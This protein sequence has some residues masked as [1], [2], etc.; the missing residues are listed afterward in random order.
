VIYAFGNF[1]MKTRLTVLAYLIS[2]SNCIAQFP[3]PGNC[4]D[5][6]GTANNYVDIADVLVDGLSVITVEA[7]IYP[8]SLPNKNNP[9]GHNN[10]EGAI[11]HKSG[12]SDDNL[13]LTV[14]TGGL[15][16]YIDNGSNNTL[17]GNAPATNT[18]THVAASYDGTTLRIYQNGILDVSQ[19]STGSNSLVNNTNNLRIGG[20]HISGGSPHEFTGR[21]DE[22]RVWSDLRTQAEIR[23]NMCQKL[24][25]TEGNLELYYRMDQTSATSV[26]DNSVNTNNGSLGPG[27][28]SSTDWVTSGAILGDKSTYS[29][30]VTTSTSLNI[31]SADGDDLTANVTA[32]IVEPE[33][34]HIYRVDE[35]PN[36]T[37]PP[38]TQVQLSQVGYFGA[39]VF[40]GTVVTY[41]VVYDYDG[42]AG[43]ADENDLELAK[44][45]DNADVDWSQETAILNTTANT[46][47]LVGETGAEYILATDNADNILPIVLLSFS[48]IQ[49]N[50]GYVELIWKTAFEINND[51]FSIERSRNG[52][53]WEILKTIDGSG[54]SNTLLSYESTDQNPYTGISY[55]R[56]KQTDFDGQFTHS[57]VSIVNIYNS[58]T[59]IQ[60]FPNPSK[61]LITIDG[62][63][64]VLDQMKIYNLHGQDVTSQTRQIHKNESTMVIDLSNLNKGLY[65]LKTK[66]TSNKVYKQ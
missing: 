48:A 7:W 15:A 16:F 62:N 40:G 34:M 47:T 30:S 37:T 22:V 3:G 60:I 38:G 56:L 18:W 8:T 11:I 25:G 41:T 12:A 13:G 55:Y 4:L 31:A 51:Y 45:D 65:Y 1:E 49:T 53:D 50:R 57:Q 32:L 5:F 26:S 59:E 28:D 14:A 27:M 46:L 61:K 66:T 44:R 58:G 20:G 36:V 43:I 52:S 39:K 64:F 54:N 17:V 35:V 63:T 33:S 10:N 24:T 19:A 21:I 9:S 23:E 29:Y 6:D 2:F 42:H